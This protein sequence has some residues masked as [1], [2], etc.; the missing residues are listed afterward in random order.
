[1]KAKRI[2]FS[3]LEVMIAILVMGMSVTGLLNLLQWGQVRYR[4][5]SE[6]WNVRS[7]YAQL[8]RH[9]R[10]EIFQGNLTK[11]SQPLLAMHLSHQLNFHIADFSVQ[12]YSQEAFFVRVRLF[13]DRNGNNREDEQEKLPPEFWCFRIRS[14]S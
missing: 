6:S 14:N 3:L 4:T 8:R 10:N 9:V 13:L 12:R 11:L 7:T 2:G 5:L 1:M